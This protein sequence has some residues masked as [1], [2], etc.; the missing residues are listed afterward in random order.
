MNY[1]QMLEEWKPRVD[2]K[3]IFNKTFNLLEPHQK[4]SYEGPKM[5]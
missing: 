1:T 5:Q 2:G 3:T 4:S